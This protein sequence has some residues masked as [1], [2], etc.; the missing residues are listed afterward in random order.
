MFMW[1]GT[2]GNHFDRWQVDDAIKSN[3]GMPL[4]SSVWFTT[5]QIEP[6][7]FYINYIDERQTKWSLWSEF[8]SFNGI[9]ISSRTHATTW[10]DVNEHSHTFP[11]IVL[12]SSFIHSHSCIIKYE[13]QVGLSANWFIVYRCALLNGAKKALNSKRMSVEMV[14]ERALRQ[15]WVKNDIEWTSLAR[16]WWDTR[17]KLSRYDTSG[18]VRA[19]TW[20]QCY[21]ELNQYS[22]WPRIRKPPQWSIMIRN[23]RS[24]SITDTFT[25]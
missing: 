21:N 2:S 5:Y 9:R 6:H 18:C 17:F 16:R 24:C 8:A 10:L 23:K 11:L 20:H 14:K 15:E 1:Y 25:L 12:N 3:N 22:S 19:R 13:S 7:R 4:I